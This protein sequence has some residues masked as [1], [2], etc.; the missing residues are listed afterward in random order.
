MGRQRFQSEIVSCWT[1]SAAISATW[2]GELA[3]D[4]QSF[5]IIGYRSFSTRRSNTALAAKP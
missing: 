1:S 2:L 5:L 3:E 4:H